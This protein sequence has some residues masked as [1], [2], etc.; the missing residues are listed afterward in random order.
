MEYIAF[1]DL[2]GIKLW[3]ENVF[4]RM[5]HHLSNNNYTPRKIPLLHEVSDVLTNDQITY[6][7]S[8]DF[9]RGRPNNALNTHKMAIALRG[10][11]SPRD[12]LYFNNL[13]PD[14]QLKLEE[15]GNSLIP[16]FNK[17]LDT[18]L[19]LSD[20]NFRA[21]ILR[22]EGASAQFGFHYDTEHPNCFR[23]LVLYDGR[24]TIPP[25]CYRDGSGALHKITFS[26]N[27]GIL[28]RGSTTHHGV[29]PSLDPNTKRY[30]VGFQYIKKDSG[31]ESRSLCNQLRGSSVSCILRLFLPYSVYYTTIGYL[32]PMVV[33]ST[34]V[35][36][37]INLCAIVV[38]LFFS[39]KIPTGNHI[40]NTLHSL[41]LF[42]VFCC[43]MTAN[44]LLA[45]SIVAYVVMTEML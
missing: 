30:L 33:V 41:G 6:L 16:S 24:S 23:A 11:Y 28:F 22:Y 34:E 19:C 14:V 42:Y 31:P 17:L 5:Y 9:D 44:L 26:V 39:T 20:T 8:V 4:R 18:E 45:L 1:D 27:H 29:E 2:F 36:L 10:N 37:T 25:F 12:A 32:P 13:D 21:I 35:T 3:H 43:A 40:P 15:I 38:G 7:R